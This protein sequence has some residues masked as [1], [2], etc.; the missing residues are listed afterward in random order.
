MTNAPIRYQLHAA[1]PW[2]LSA[3]WPLSR[4]VHA[5]SYARQNLGRPYILHR[6][7][8][9]AARALDSAPPA[10]RGI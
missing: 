3:V 5:W 7:R 4:L 8:H 6:R 1:P 10:E 2:M 9:P